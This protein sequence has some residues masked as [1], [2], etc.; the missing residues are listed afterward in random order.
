[1]KQH[2]AKLAVGIIA[3]GLP[4]QTWAQDE[5]QA[6]SAEGHFGPQ[7][8]WSVITEVK[9]TNL[10]HQPLGRIQDL[11]LDLSNGRVVEVLI[12]SDQFLRMGG[13]T[14]AVPPE[15]LIPDAANKTYMINVSAEAFKAAPKFD[16]K[17]WADSTQTDNV[18]AAYQY[19][20]Q[21][22]YF[23]LTNEASRNTASGEAVVHLG[24]VERMSKLINMP[25][26]NLQGRNLGK[27]QTLVLD[28]PNGRI[29]SA[30][31]NAD[32][33]GQTLKYSSV[34]PPTEL[35]FNT[36]RNGLLLDDTK[37]EYSQEPHVIF[38]DGSAGQK[39]SFREQPG[40]DDAIRSGLVQGTGSSDINM[41][42]QI[43]KSIQSGKLDRANKVEVATLAGRVTIAGT[44]NTQAAKDGIDAIA[45]AA[46]KAENVDNQITV[47]G[48]SQASL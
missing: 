29:T 10:E 43:Y 47:D 14:V 9:I 35:T 31:I 4:L 38:Q 22:P 45:N 34:V 28:V 23:L 41:T 8:H 5:T 27:L 39:S 42:A 36:K 7:T 30:F 17:A 21:E 40:N 33:I 1:M 48:Q 3:L 16:L 24:I 25:V 44:V 2:L 13:K 19:F 18:A 12:V 37:V 15:A 32:Y 6:I 26:D 46:V 20:R 11:V